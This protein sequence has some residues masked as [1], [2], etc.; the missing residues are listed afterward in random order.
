[1]LYFKYTTGHSRLTT[2]DQTLLCKEGGFNV[3]YIVNSMDHFLPEE[4]NFKFFWNWHVPPNS[5]VFNFR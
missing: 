3:S 4:R 2:K 1:M 5:P